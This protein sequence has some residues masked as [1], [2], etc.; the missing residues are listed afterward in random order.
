MSHAVKS[1]GAVKTSSL[2][3]TQGRGAGTY[4]FIIVESGKR[5]QKDI[6]K[7]CVGR[8]HLMKKCYRRKVV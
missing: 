5:F 6:I 7:I 2:P 8:R 1:S 3:H 4:G